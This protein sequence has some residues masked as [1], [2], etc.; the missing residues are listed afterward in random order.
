MLD[1]TTH[2]KLLKRVDALGREIEHLKRDLLRS[3]GTKSQRQKKKPSLF[4]SVQGK[5]VTEET[6]ESAKQKLFRNLEDL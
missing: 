2:E 4:G 5:D 3:L 1:K 6:I